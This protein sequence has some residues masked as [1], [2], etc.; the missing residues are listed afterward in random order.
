MCQCEVNGCIVL[1]IES[2]VVQQL[3]KTSD[4]AKI[5]VVLS[6]LSVQLTAVIK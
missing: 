4:V 6:P 2:V 3:A 1:N 5:C